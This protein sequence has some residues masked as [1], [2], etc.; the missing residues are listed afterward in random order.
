MVRSN[1][2]LVPPNFGWFLMP[3]IPSHFEVSTHLFFLLP[4][5][6]LLI[7]FHLLLSFPCLLNSPRP[8]FPFGKEKQ[9]LIVLSIKWISK[10]LAQ[11][12]TGSSKTSLT[13]SFDLLQGQYEIQ[14]TIEM[15]V[16]YFFHLKYHGELE[17]FENTWVLKI[18]VWKHIGST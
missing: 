8:V 16:V 18:Q 12:L 14:N 17:R 2:Y 4:C 7:L 13:L 9:W 10:L 6:F 1:N 3:L 15:L 5:L 11:C